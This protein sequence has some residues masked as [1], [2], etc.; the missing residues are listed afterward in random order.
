MRLVENLSHPLINALGWTLL[1]ALW[2]IL[3]VALLWR[4]I[5]FISRKASASIRYNITLIALLSIPVICGFTFYRQYQIYQAA[6][7]IVSI[8]FADGVYS[9]NSPNS[10]SFSLVQK[11]YP[12]FLAGLENLT[13]YL[14]WI[15][16]AGLLVLSIYTMASY[17]R[18]HQLKN[19][20]ISPIPLLWQQKAQSFKTQMGLK[21]GVRIFQS[22]KVTVPVMVGFF[23]PVIL[24]PLAM[25]SSLSTEQVESILLHEMYHLRRN[26]HYVNVLQN[27]LEILFFFH[28]ATWWVSRHL[29]EERENCVDEWVVKFTSTPLVYAQ[30]LI[31]LEENRSA[32]L[33][34]V[35]AATQSK[36]LLL[37]R[38]KNIMAMKTKKFNPGQKLAALLVII[39]AAISVAWINPTLSINHGQPGIDYKPEAYPLSYYNANRSEPELVMEN[40]PPQSPVTIPEAE[41]T[42][43][44]KEPEKIILKDGKAIAWS[45]LSE[46]DREKIRDA[47]RE[48]RIA[49]EEASLE[50]QATFN[51]EAFREQMR[52][53]RLD[54]LKSQ[55]EVQR[56]LHEAHAETNDYFQ[57]E[58][59]RQEMEKAQQEMKKAIEEAGREMEYFRTEEFQQDMEKAREAFRKAMEEASRE[60]EHF[61]SEEFKLEIEKA[62][63]EMKKALEEMRREFRESGNES[64][65]IRV[66][67]DSMELEGFSRIMEMT[68]LALEENL[69]Y[70]GPLVQESV[71]AFDVEEIL[72]SML[73][74][75]EEPLPEEPR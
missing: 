58:E 14:V 32:T 29:R 54:I 65:R 49:M 22:S 23:K 25:L 69:Q 19:R 28:P 11:N 20:Y 66:M 72:N 21:R 61:K 71:E 53:A 63:E 5:L 48:A 16:L 45:E 12:G 75:L 8:E 18:I 9:A 52:Q 1:H 15:Y 42:L 67:M 37:T 74:T 60:M 55:E 36:S 7:P 2:Q 73:N 31:T 47:M 59:F 30:A 4:S 40:Q 68:L 44:Q 62:R 56:A 34:P 41:D 43:T 38:I 24:L 35:L 33:Q 13:P 51:S 6:S 39:T 70:I 3:L 10:N 26:D 50:I 57:S 64:E 46:E 27:I 17:A